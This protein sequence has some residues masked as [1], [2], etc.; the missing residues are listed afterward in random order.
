M[1]ATPGD[2]IVVYDITSLS[3]FPV[4]YISKYLEMVRNDTI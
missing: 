2:H 4:M 1:E 3:K